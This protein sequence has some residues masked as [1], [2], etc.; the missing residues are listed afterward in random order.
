MNKL[1]DLQAYLYGNHLNI[2]AITEKFLSQEVT[3][4]E[5]ISSGYVFRRDRN[6]HGGGVMLI[7]SD[8]I[9]S[10]RRQDLESTCELQW[11]E[12]K[13]NPSNLL[14]GVFYNPPSSGCDPIIHLRGFTSWST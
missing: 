4:G 7:V 14:V 2:L 1:L 11:V 5:I 8:S 6:H 9:P 3:N 10:V 12:L 13:L